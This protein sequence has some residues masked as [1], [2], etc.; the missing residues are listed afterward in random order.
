MQYDVHTHIGLDA[1]FYLRGW[2]PYAS[3]AADLLAQMDA[4]GIDRAICFPFTLSS[5]FDIEAFATDN[6]IKLLPGRVPFD[7]ENA[8]LAQEIERVGNNR[9]LQFVMFDPSREVARQV[10]AIKPLLG[11]IVGLKTQSTV[12][13][14][15][16]KA[17]LNAGRA[18]ME[19][20][21]QNDLPVLFH[22]S[23]NDPWAQVSDCLG[24]ARA[25]PN[26]RFNL[27]HSCRFH[28]PLLRECATAPNVWVDCSAHLAHCQLA[29]DNLAAV[30]PAGERVQ[31]DYTRPERVLE[32]IYAILGD[33]YMWGSD[34][35]FMSWY[36]DKLRIRY[37]YAQEMDVI[38]ALRESV[39]RSML[40]DAPQAWLFGDN[41]GDRKEPT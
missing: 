38:R 6:A 11:R 26:V 17:L 40:T 15:P 29:R 22:T 35:P 12:I 1:G 23:V 16:V 31:A 14:S 5:A 18:L 8:L 19:L 25:F 28:A 3:T 9:L 34:N 30:A 32:A 39:R 7:R 4:H 41:G 2:W 13:R 36:D 33:K 27:A 21:E 37:T 10:E 20:A 24:I